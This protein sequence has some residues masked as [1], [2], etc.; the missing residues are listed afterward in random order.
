MPKKPLLADILLVDDSHYD[1]VLTKIMLERD[2]VIVNIIAVGDGR[3]ALAYLEKLPPFEAADMPDLILLDL[4]MPDINGFSVLTAMRE[5]NWL[6]NIPVVICSGSDNEKDLEEVRQFGI[7]DYL[8]KPLEYSKLAPI[9][10]RIPKIKV[11][12]TEDHHFICRCA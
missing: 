12:V 5:R 3:E 2:K 11:D 8:V 7:R 1:V 9:L 4:N 6:P 10:E